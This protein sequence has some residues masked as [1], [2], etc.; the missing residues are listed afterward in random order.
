[1]KII[2][3]LLIIA[4]LGSVEYVTCCTYEY[5]MDYRG[6][7]ANIDLEWAASTTQ[8]MCCDLCNRNSQCN[9]WTFVT[10]TKVCW[11]KKSIGTKVATSGSKLI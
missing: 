9:A 4:S 3:T 5:N 11:L 2:L 10:E 8:E 6:I 7:L 1:M